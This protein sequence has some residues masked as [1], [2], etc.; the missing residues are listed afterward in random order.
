[1]PSWPQ[2][3]TIVGTSVPRVDGFLKVSGQ[4]KYSFDVNLPGLLHGKILRCPHAHAR[5]VSIDVGPA[6]AMAGVK[7]VY[8]IKKPG[9]ELRYAGDEIAAVAAVNEETA[10]EAIRAIEVK[11]QKLDH[12]STEADGLK[13]GPPVAQAGNFDERGD[14]ADQALSKAAAVVEGTY[15][16]NVVT[17]VC[18]E[19]HGLVA[20][21][22]GDELTVWASTQGVGATA[23][24]LRRHFNKPATCLTKFMGGGFGSKFGPDVQG[25]AAA[26][27]ARE[28]GAPVK[29]MLERSEEHNAAGNRPSAF[30]KVK[31][32]CSA[33]GKL[34]ALDA[35]TWGTG[36][37]TRDANFPLPYI[38]LVPNRRRQHTNVSTNAGDQRAMRAP[39]HPQGSLIMES[40]MDDL[41]HKL[42]PNLDPVE[43]RLRN[44]PT[45]NLRAIWTHELQLGAALIG[46]REKWHPRGAASH[47]P[48][49][50][51]LGCALSTWGGGPGG[52]QA[53]AVIHADGRVEV[54]CGTQDLGTGTTT[55]VRLVAAEFLGLAVHQIDG[56][57]GSSALPPAGASGGSTSCGGVS[58][59]VA[60]AA[61]KAR[62][63]L[64]KV[65]AGELGVKPEELEA[66]GGRV[67]QKGDSE[68]GFTWRQACARV[69]PGKSIVANADKDEG[70]GMAASG[71]GGAQFAEVSVDVET[72]VVRVERIVAVADCGLVVNRMLCESQ[73]YGGVIGGLN[74]AIHEE[75]RLDRATG[76]PLNADMEHYRLASASDIPQ[77]DVHLLD[78]PERG[79]IGIGEPPTIPTASAIANAVANAIGVRVPMI[80]LTPARVL[81]ALA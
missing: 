74:Y 66:A 18:L 42:D 27:L 56:E 39:G 34:L 14:P 57:I 25:I 67:H 77:I 52:A 1:M 73:V 80:P 7:A 81:A 29:L 79:V 26:E 10:R 78:Y 76:L 40:A 32:G 4:A 8:L 45:G 37:H 30:A 54:K 17:H 35:Q 69:G 75:R 61:T 68:K 11:Y 51:G 72:G 62:D 28:A 20:E 9:D 44:L 41:C 12:V 70:Q 46:W 65:V 47:G 64:F 31:L 50:R 49:R 3:R 43:F 21:W 60:V 55:L 53:T 2:K 13:L 63:E 48:V 59:A 6:K 33:D 15:G 19:S 5:I 58:V 71:V 36:G 24:G 38:Y 22:K 16:C 23:D